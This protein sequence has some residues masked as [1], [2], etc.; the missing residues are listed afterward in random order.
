[1]KSL[2]LYLPDLDPYSSYTIAL[3]ATSDYGTGPLSEE[4]KV[5]TFEDGRL[6]Y[7]SCC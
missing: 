4:I 7:L 1:M 5:K 2:L 6:Q 3:A